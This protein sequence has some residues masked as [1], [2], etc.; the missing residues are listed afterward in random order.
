MGEVADDQFFNKCSARCSRTGNLKIIKHLAAADRVK[1]SGVSLSH[2]IR[3]EQ[4]HRMAGTNEDVTMRMKKN[5]FSW[6]G[7]VERMRER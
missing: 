4:I 7:H 3:N 1:V 2:L 5:V 6:F